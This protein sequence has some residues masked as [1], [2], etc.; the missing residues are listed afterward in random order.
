[1]H[2]GVSPTLALYLGKRYLTS[3]FLTALVIS[4]LVFILELVEISRKLGTK[5]GL[6]EGIGLKMVFLK[7]PDMVL[8]IVP[9][10]ILLGTLI[11][12]ARLT[13]NQELTA[14][15]A[16]GLPARQFLVPP[17]VVCLA[18]G[19][20]N[21]LA[22]NPLAATMLKQYEHIHNEIFPGS[23]Q[24]LVTNG[25]Q[26]WLKQREE[27]EEI[28]IYAQQVTENGHNLEQATLF[29]FDSRGNFETRLDAK[30]MV[31][32]EKEWLLTDVVRITPG[33]PSEKTD[34]YIL[35]TTLRPEMIQNSF[36]SPNTLSIWEMHK[37]I[38]LLKSTGFPSQKHELYWHKLL[39]SPALILSMFLLA[40]PFALH[41]SRSRS[42]GSILLLG[43][44]FGFLFYF[45]T[46]LVST[47]GLAGAINLA[48]AAWLPT[49]IAAF[50]GLSFFLHFREE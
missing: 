26:I 8:Q 16:C 15:R 48:V 13:K 14:I 25:G 44:V 40:A 11:C 17:I 18:V 7:M 35:P 3:I 46:N 33:E 30:K 6:E 39:A 5:T 49:V 50:L 34:S 24:G 31:L 10:I 28:L 23:T 38:A 27:N 22:F 21:V 19:I 29:L 42:T 1:M 37:F 32:K 45:F 9:F 12:F 4:T 43:L 20:F 36:T 2:R 47:Q 41:F